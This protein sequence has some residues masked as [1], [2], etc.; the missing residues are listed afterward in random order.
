MGSL[1]PKFNWQYIQAGFATPAARIIQKHMML[2]YGRSELRSCAAQRSIAPKI[3]IIL[4]TNFG[5]RTE[6]P[7]QWMP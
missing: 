5:S 1:S 2:S 7:S 6:F 4:R 3:I